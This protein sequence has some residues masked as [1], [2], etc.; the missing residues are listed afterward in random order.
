MTH[1]QPAPENDW[2]PKAACRGHDPDLWVGWEGES[3]NAHEA[4]EAAAKR[5]CATC[6]VRTHCPIP[7]H[8]HP[9]AYGNGG[10]LNHHQLGAERYPRGLNPAPRSDY[11]RLIPCDGCNNTNPHSG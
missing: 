2:H 10:G 1:L 6:P 11:H 4:G 8:T 7:A 5:T 3:N 9:D